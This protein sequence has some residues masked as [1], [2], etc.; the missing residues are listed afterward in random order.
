MRSLKVKI[1]AFVLG[2][3][4]LMGP[5]FTNN[6]ILSVPPPAQTAQ[7]AMIAIT[8][9]GNFVVTSTEIWA[10]SPTCGGT[11]FT[12]GTPGQ[13]KAAA[14]N[15]KC[16]F[17]SGGTLV[18]GNNVTPDPTTN[19]VAPKTCWTRVS[20][21]GGGTVP[22]CIGATIAG[23]SF[24]LNNQF[25]P[26]GKY[27]F[28]LKNPDGSSRIENLKVELSGDASQV[29]YPGHM[30]ELGDPFANNCLLNFLYLG[31]A[32]QNGSIQSKLH[33]PTTL[34]AATMGDIL[35]SDSFKP[36]NAGC[37][38][39]AIAHMDQVCYN[40]GP[41]SYTVTITGRI[42]GVDGNANLS[43]VGTAQ[44]TINAENCQ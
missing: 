9:G 12:G 39:T 34:G 40:L 42:K 13:R 4:V 20:S 6:V 24:V 41:G 29:D 23:E 26:N 8:G 31:N 37:P 33:T 38:Y 10:F 7:S 2:S 25:W 21:S 14:T 30:L 16:T 22:V 43:F 15:Q 19:P 3:A 5:T 18:P 32:G 44:I 36:N 11:Y 35:N 17:W 27:S 28:T 1:A